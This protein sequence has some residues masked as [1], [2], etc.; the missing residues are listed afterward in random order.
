MTRQVLIY[1]DKHE[2]ISAVS[3]RFIRTA[4][5]TI[6]NQD[7]MHVVL[8]GGSVGIGI[9]EAIN[10]SPDRD[11]VDWSKVHIWW[12]DERWVAGGHEDRNDRQATDALLGHVHLRSENVH[13]FPIANPGLELDAAALRYADE[14]SVAGW[15]DELPHFDLLLLGVGP[16]GHIA[17]LF[18]DRAELID[19]NATVVA[20]RN[21]PK[22]PPERLSLTLR[23]INS[24]ERIWLA[25][26]GA[27]KASAL[28]LALAGASPYQVPVAGAKGR[29]RTVF[30]VDKDAATQVPGDLISSEY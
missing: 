13:P 1:A 9:L 28:G 25:V 20:V 7:V 23:V 27:D 18:P 2:L 11:N 22:P 16:D 30:F 19:S 15:P 6:A 12:G 24:A 14:L 17:S 4:V 21:S 26:A 8:T 5:R 29:R 3:A 10:L